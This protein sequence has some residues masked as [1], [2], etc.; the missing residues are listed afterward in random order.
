M[1]ATF[2][3]PED[4]KRL[5]HRQAFEISDHR[6]RD[7][8]AALWQALE[9]MQEEDRR[10]L[11]ATL[12][13]PPLNLV[14][15]EQERAELGAL[16]ERRECPLVTLVGPGGVGKTSLALQVAADRAA[17]FPD[18]AHFVPLASLTD[19]Q[20]VLATVAQALG[21]LPPP[22]TSVAE[23]LAAFLR[24]APRRLL[25]LDN[26]EH[27]RAAAPEIGALLGQVRTLKVLATSRT[28][29]RLHDEQQYVVAPLAA[30]S[31]ADLFLQTA[32]R[33]RPGWSPA[34]E[35]DA[36][37]AELCR[38]LDGLPLAI[39]L[40]A[41]R[42]KLLPVRTLLGRL[43]RRLPCSRP[44]RPTPRP[45]IRRCATPSTGAMAC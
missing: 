38:R 24:Q 23:A 4:L 42:V 6:W 7:G 33:M 11:P 39:E 31:A 2:D 27:L 21:V 37:V 36:A 15:R 9:A 17:L 8:V 29:L 10:V 12:P 16:L 19:P 20:L 40:A 3:L 5:A 34:A 1:P 22:S 43:D 14:G 26:L 32:R 30:A 25:V 35:D 18:G 28:P 44:A 45:A 41:A 13:A